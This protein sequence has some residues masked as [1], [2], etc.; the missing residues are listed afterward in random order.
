MTDRSPPDPTLLG[1][2]HAEVK[3]H[4]ATLSAGVL[5]LG[6]TP[7]DPKQLESLMR[8]A[9]SIKGAAKIVGFDAAVQVSHHMED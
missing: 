4:L 9:H 7:E 5:S 3:T 2:F 1:L 8:A 6:Q